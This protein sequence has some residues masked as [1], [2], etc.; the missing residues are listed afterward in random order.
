MKAE[1]L[2]AVQTD[3]LPGTA[4]VGALGDHPEET[5]SRLFLDAT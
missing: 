4:R 3:E 2:A 1:E 5:E